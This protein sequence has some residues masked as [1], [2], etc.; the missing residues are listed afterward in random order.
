MAENT[1]E[2]TLNSALLTKDLPL[3][4]V[5]MTSQGP[6]VLVGDEQLSDGREEPHPPSSESAVMHPPLHG[7]TILPMSTGVPILPMQS[8]QITG[9][10]QIAS[11]PLTWI[12]KIDRFVISNAGTVGGSADWIVNDIKIS[13]VSQFVQSGDVSGAVFAA[14]A[15]DAPN[16]IDK[17]VRFNPVQITMDAVVVVV[18]YI[19]H[20]AMGCPFFGAMVGTVV[21]TAS[22]EV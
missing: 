16:E 14:N 11:C 4:R 2:T 19:G 7:K 1:A 13:G 12:Y 17:F 10:I 15:T 5:K 9:H 20:N 18:T 21:D 3:V 6:H 8:A 22:A